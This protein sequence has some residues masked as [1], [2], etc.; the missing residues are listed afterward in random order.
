MTQ[1][2]VTRRVNDAS[3]SIADELRFNCGFEHGM[4]AR[5][6]SILAE[7]VAPFQAQV[8]LTRETSGKSADVRSVL[9]VVALDVT[10]G[11]SCII[12]AVG[13]D[14]EH[15]VAALRAVID[16]GLGESASGQ[17]GL[18]T[19]PSVARVPAGLL[20][21]GVKWIGGRGVSPGSAQGSVVIVRPLEAAESSPFSGSIEVEQASALRAFEEARQAIQARFAATGAGLER[22][23]LRAHLAIVDDLALRAKVDQEITT[24]VSAV[25]A[26]RRAGRHFIDTLLQA[27]SQYIRDRAIDVEDV[28]EQIVERLEGAQGAGAIELGA[29]A[30]IVADR[31]TPR[32]L[33]TLNR[34][35]VLALVLDRVGLTSHTVILARAFGIPTI[36]GATGA[37]FQ[38]GEEVIV[39]ADHGFI[40]QE[41]TDEVRRYYVIEQRAMSQRRKR[42]EPFAP[43]AARTRDGVRLDIG[44]NISL[45]TEVGGA[46][47]DGAEGIGLFRTEMLFLD[48]AGPPSEQEQFEAYVQAIQA[49]QGRAVIIRTLDIGGDKPVP[50]L[51]LDREDNPFLGRR[52]IR[53]Y[54]QF[55]DLLR[56]QLRAIARASAQGPVK[57]MAPMVS[58]PA[59]AAWFRQ[60]VRE[61]QNELRAEGAAFDAAMPVGVMIEVPAAALAM[62]HLAE[63]A[64]FFSIGTNDLCQYFLAADRGN[65]G[66]A[67]LCDPC[68]PSFLRFLKIIVDAARRHQR[69]VG[70][71]GEMAG[72][73]ANLP[74]MVGLGLDEI[75]VSAARLLELK[76]AIASLESRACVDLI[77]QIHLCS[78]ARE[79][80]ILLEQFGSA[81]GATAMIEPGLVAMDCDAATKVEAIKHLVS[82]IAVAGRA[83]DSHSLEHAVWAREE[84]YSTGLGHGFAIPHCKAEAVRT[85][86]IAVAKFAQPIEWGS[87]DGDPVRVA[88]MLAVPAVGT[89]AEVARAHMQVLA[90]LARSL[91]HEEFRERI[92]HA[93]TAETVVAALSEGLDH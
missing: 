45:A 14:A 25:A 74:I 31:L 42:L 64:D 86:T 26:V 2:K 24:G 71:C 32:Q 82:L 29:P 69:W 20:R 4:H 53:L 36:V 47:G 13:D 9:S 81:D 35:H 89:V 66:V 52:G 61:I 46:I 67:D 5:P 19:S 38:G 22:D 77:E 58:N 57:V 88:I 83:A 76:A 7:A 15:A 23:L 84:T 12:R 11:E 18:V 93:T 34:A 72:E 73:P 79:V 91:M 92:M 10:H 87:N 44:A 59:E 80:R 8:H 78:D 62:D 56:Q 41:L 85:A 48:R 28:C 33:M 75:S 21:L 6:A 30:V 16:Q 60:Q 37:A 55:P 49:A 39:D 51:R 50:Y 70:V 3:T 68:T 63:H 17:P 65:P 90:K 43:I 54:E 27:N 40:I 1:R